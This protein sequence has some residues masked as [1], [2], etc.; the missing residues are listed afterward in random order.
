MYHTGE[1]V[2]LRVFLKPYALTPTYRSTNKFT[3]K[4]FLNLVLVDEEDRRCRVA[5]GF[6]CT[7]YRSVLEEGRGGAVRQT[8]VLCVCA[9]F[10]ISGGGEGEQAE[11]SL[12]RRD[13]RTRMPVR[14]RGLDA[15]RHLGVVG[16]AQLD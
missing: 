6:M 14:C 5:F 11:R 16:A 2:P 1:C 13:G 9:C 10:C 3:V 8:G 4:Y 12:A 15:L 7:F